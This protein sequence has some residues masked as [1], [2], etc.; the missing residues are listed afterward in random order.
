MGKAISRIVVV[1]SVLA[2]VALPGCHIALQRYLDTPLVIKESTAYYDL[3]RGSSFGI[4]ANELA[5]QDI[6]DH[7]ELLTLWARLT[8]QAGQIKAGEYQLEEGMT[9]RDV[10]ELFVSGSV[11]NYSVTLVEGWTWRQALAELHGQPKLEKKLAGLSNEQLM[12]RLGLEED[13]P[14]PEGLFFPDTYNYR[15]GESDRDIMLRAHQRLVNMLDTLWLQREEGLPYDNKY[16]ALI[17][18]SIVEKETGLASERATIAG[19]FVNR[20]RKGMRLQTDPTVIYGLGDSYQGNLT[21]KH[22][23][24]PGPYNSYMIKGLPPTPIALVG[25]EAINAALHPAK[26]SKLYFVA[27]GDGSHYFSETLAEHQKA[28]K[29]Y[30]LERRSATYRSAPGTT[31]KKQVP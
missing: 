1:A 16:Q 31:L 17:M 18:A 29:K 6:L 13:W 12:G 2:L 19:V 4:A 24:T 22:L 27:R 8:G 30:Q 7:P 20:L 9:R 5:S 28:V 14:H 3:A 25:E 10:V 21:R 11:I 15:R 26:T 23:R